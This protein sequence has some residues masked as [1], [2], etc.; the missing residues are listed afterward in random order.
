MRYSKEDFVKTTSCRS[1]VGRSPF[2]R[3]SFRGSWRQGEQRAN[4]GASR[5]GKGRGEEDAIAGCAW[6]ETDIVDD[7]VENKY[8]RDEAMLCPK[9]A[10][11]PDTAS[12]P[13]MGAHLIAYLP[14]INP[15]PS[16]KVRALPPSRL[17]ARP[18]FATTDNPH[19]TS[20]HPSQCYLE[21]R[22]KDVGR[23]LMRRG[24]T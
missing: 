4:S 16:V 9:A 12:L 8:E 19:A 13:C 10:M 20:I 22:L 3:P 2:G 14:P 21:P 1:G 24:T 18:P 5:Q 11:D 17:T 23:I 7:D 6:G 15:R